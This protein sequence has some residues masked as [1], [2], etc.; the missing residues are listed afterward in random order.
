MNKQCH[1]LFF[2]LFFCVLNEECESGGFMTVKTVVWMDSTELRGKKKSM[3]IVGFNYFSGLTCMPKFLPNKNK[4]RQK[5]ILTC[6]GVK[7]NV[8]T[9]LLLVQ[10]ISWMVEEQQ[11]ISYCSSIVQAVDYTRAWKGWNYYKKCIQKRTH[12]FCLYFLGIGG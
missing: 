5:A 10:S 4:Y 3:T 11:S 12:G 6:P 9:P 1:N 8:K 2:F 7:T